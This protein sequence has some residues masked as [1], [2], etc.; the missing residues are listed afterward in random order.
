M[1]SEYWQGPAWCSDL[2]GGDI[3]KQRLGIGPS[4]L[5]VPPV[6]WR[7]SGQVFCPSAQSAMI[8]SYNFSFRFHSSKS[9]IQLIETHLFIMRC[10]T[11]DIHTWDAGRWSFYTL[12]TASLQ[13]LQ[14]Y[15]V[16]SSQF[17]SLYSLILFSWDSNLLC[18]PAGS[19]CPR[20]KQFS[21]LIFSSCRDFRGDPL[22]H[23]GFMEMNIQ[24]YR[25]LQTA[26]SLSSAPL[27]EVLPL[28]YEWVGED[29]LKGGRSTDLLRTR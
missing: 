28:G 22:C 7:S 24:R 26:L 3:R 8:G 25:C 6:T 18:C 12:Q 10:I 5:P 15:G 17:Y 23:S 9:L 21:C 19:L 20:L 14:E 13:D 4:L 11:K 29:S 27:T 16:Q 1:F 2:P